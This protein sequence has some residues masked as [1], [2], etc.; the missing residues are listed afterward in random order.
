MVPAF[1]PCWYVFRPS[2]PYPCKSCSVQ[3]NSELLQIRLQNH[4]RTIEAYLQ[5]LL[6]R[7][8]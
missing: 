3:P 7:E 1:N 5:K 2:F 6:E 8:T 4:C